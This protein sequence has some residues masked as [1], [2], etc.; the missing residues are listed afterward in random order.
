[1]GYPN[2]SPVIKGARITMRYI[3]IFIILFLIAG[4]TPSTKI[5]L[6]NNTDT[7]IVI[8]FLGSKNSNTIE[9][10]QSVELYNEF[11]DFKIETKN[12]RYIYDE[13]A[14]FLSINDEL[15]SYV[16][17]KVPIG[18]EIKLQFQMN[19][20]IFILSKSKEFPELDTNKQP[21]GFPLRPRLK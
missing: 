8:T 13:A 19:G 4:C 3:C 20:N 16:N 10:M 18:Y 2:V 6:Y 1:M 12:Y 17:K 14:N 11:S 15:N 9:P 21:S 5:N 7:A